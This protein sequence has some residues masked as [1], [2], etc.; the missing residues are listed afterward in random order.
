MNG[1]D[2][3][4]STRMS[5]LVDFRFFKWP[6][7]GALPRNLRSSGLSVVELFPERRSPLTGVS[8]GW[9]A[10]FSTAEAAVPSLAA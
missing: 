8:K 1:M 10:F 4:G 9:S 5:R 7:A 3:D 2:A 6:H